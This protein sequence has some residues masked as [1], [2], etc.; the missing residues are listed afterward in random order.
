MFNGRIV[1]WSDTHTDLDVAGWEM[2]RKSGRRCTACRRLCK[3]HPGPT[4]S[5]CA[6]AAAA[7]RLGVDPEDIEEFPPL[8]KP[9]GAQGVSAEDAAY[10][11]PP[12]S[13]HPLSYDRVTVSGD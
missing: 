8:S 10:Q 7:A 9:S 4:G 11:T 1:S 5:N 3:G 2:V 13:P 12:G 6:I